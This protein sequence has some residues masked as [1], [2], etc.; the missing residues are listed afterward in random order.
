MTK[1]YQ[2]KIKHGQ[3]DKGALWWLW[4]IPLTL[5]LLL[6]YLLLRKRKVLLDPCVLKE[7]NLNTVIK[8]LRK[9]GYSKIYLNEDFILSQYSIKEHII[10]QNMRKYIIDDKHTYNDAYIISKAKREKIM[11]PLLPLESI[12]L[13]KME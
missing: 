13:K 10:K 7:T 12:F 3:S 6:L 2:D 4:L 8:F 5:L 1:L 9:K 11:L